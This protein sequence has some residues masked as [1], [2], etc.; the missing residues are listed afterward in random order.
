M[1]S[2]KHIIHVPVCFSKLLGLHVHLGQAQHTLTLHC[3]IQEVPN[4]ELLNSTWHRNLNNKTKKD[5][6]F[7]LLLFLKYSPYQKSL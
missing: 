1:Q 5:R 6:V 2:I 3:L 4:S 7:F